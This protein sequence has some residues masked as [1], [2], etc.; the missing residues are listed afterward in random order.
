MENQARTQT[1]IQ[2]HHTD[3]GKSIES[4]EEDTFFKPV[5]IH[6]LLSE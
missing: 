4:T 3:Q 1:G 5:T 6:A 2:K